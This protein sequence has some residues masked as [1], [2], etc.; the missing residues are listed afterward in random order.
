MTHDVCD[1]CWG[2]GLHDRPWPSHRNQDL[3][4]RLIV[5]VRKLI[6]AVRPYCKDDP[7][8]AE[9]WVD[10]RRSLP[11]KLVGSGDEQGSDA[12]D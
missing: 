5:E 10:V 4:E 2:S 7:K 12:S 8:V 3:L 11:I 1:V 6:T 9:A